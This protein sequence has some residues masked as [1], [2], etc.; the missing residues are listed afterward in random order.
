MGRGVEDGGLAA[1][2]PALLTRL[3]QTGEAFAALR[4]GDVA[5][6][7]GEDG[8]VH[9]GLFGHLHHAE[10]AARGFVGFHQLPHAGE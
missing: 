6:P 8:G 2:H 4:A 10:V 3:E 5:M 7:V 9:D 1:F